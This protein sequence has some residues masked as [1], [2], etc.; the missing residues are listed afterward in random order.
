MLGAI[1]GDVIGSAYEWDRTK[2]TDFDLFTPK[3]N[4]TDDSVMTIATA[5]AIMNDAPYG[6]AY[7]VLGNK[8]PGRG[9]GGRFRQ[10]L[11][12]DEMPP[13]YNSWGNGSAMRV[14]LVGW[15]FGDYTDVM[16]EAKKSAECTHNHPEGI[17]GAQA[18]A[19]AIWMARNGRPKEEIRDHIINNFGYNLSRT[20][21]DIRPDYKF[22]EECAETVPQALVAFFD[23]TD[24]EN[25]IRL[26]I[27]LGGDSD[28]LACITGAVAEAFYGSDALPES[29]VVPVWGK[30]PVEFK[31]TLMDFHEE[32][33][34]R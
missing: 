14:A 23:S 22:T 29:L 4:F 5:M 11:A 18:T 31:F 16:N 2:E 1:I 19:I 33:I 8:Y 7:R 3:T 28:T 30:L 25:A 12:A 9:Y 10:W 13:P 24:F 21:D 26:S 15:A 34:S 32:F 20:V 6:E 27:S 17:K